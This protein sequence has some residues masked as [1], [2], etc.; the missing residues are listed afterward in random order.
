M[1]LIALLICGFVAACAGTESRR[2]QSSC[3][4]KSGETPECACSANDVCI[5]LD[6]AVFAELFGG[7]DGAKPTVRQLAALRRIAVRKDEPLRHDL[8]SVIDACDI[9]GER[10]VLVMKK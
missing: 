7:A 2:S 4:I 1:R 3:V 6:P 10:C 5:A 8:L 9:A